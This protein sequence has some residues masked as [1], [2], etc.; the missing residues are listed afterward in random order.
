MGM[1][2]SHPLVPFYRRYRNTKVEPA[3]QHKP[4]LQYYYNDKRQPLQLQHN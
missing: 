3:V 4:R 2:S 1:K